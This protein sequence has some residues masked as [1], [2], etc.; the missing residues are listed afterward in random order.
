MKIGIEAYWT[1]KAGNFPEEY[2][3]ALDYKITPASMRLCIA[4]GATM[5]PFSKR[6]VDILTTKFVEKLPAFLW[7]NKSIESKAKQFQDWL[8]AGALEWKSHIDFSKIPAHVFLNMKKGAYGTIL[9]IH[10]HFRS[11]VWR[12]VAVGDCEMFIVRESKLFLP[13]SMPGI[14]T[15]SAWPVTDPKQFGNAPD[16][17]YTNPQ[18]NR[19]LEGQLKISKGKYKSGDI[20]MLA[21]DAL[22]KHILEYGPP[23]R[24][25]SKVVFSKFIETERD[26]DRLKNDDVTLVIVKI[27]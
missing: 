6:W 13:N 20:I 24:F 17:V 25:A 21:T 14:Y 23:P 8:L 27:S 26:A 9:G 11:Q 10:M 4:D 1:Q 16:L 19:S 7:T 12:S 18:M 15:T 5:A 3:D 2:E 22:A